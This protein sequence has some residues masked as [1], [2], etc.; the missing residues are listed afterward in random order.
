MDMHW[1]TALA[2]WSTAHP[3]LMGLSVLL[4]ACAES[5]AIVGLLV[6]GASLL[7]ACGALIGLG[8]LPLAPIWAWAVAGAVIGDWASFWLGRRMRSR[9]RGLWPLNRHPEWL[10]RGERFF[11]HHGGK[12][13]AIGRFVGPVRA[14]VPLIAGMLDMSPRRF[15][16]LNLL[17][18]L[19]WA[20]A[21]LL[22]GMALAAT[23]D[24]AG[25]V[26]TRLLAVALV[27]LVLLWLLWQV[28]TLLL[29]RRPRPLYLRIAAAAALLVFGI[30]LHPLAADLSTPSDTA[31]WVGSRQ[32]LASALQQE[33]WS[34]PRPSREAW[35]AALDP[36]APLAALP[37]TPNWQPPDAIWV[38]GDHHGE[39]QVLR[40]WFDTHSPAAQPQWHAALSHQYRRACGWL[41][42]WAENPATAPAPPQPAALT[43]D[44]NAPARITASG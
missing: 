1:F 19:L 35:L 20:P 44:G 3:Q 10:E 17:S 23:L 33:G 29:S 43:G 39:R 12:S 40:L 36:A 24:R 37:V 25:P 9:T 5:L 30:V 15:M 16:L 22:P 31:L 2:D 6:P 38:R 13:V 34:R 41:A 14:V 4:I 7:L 42:C 18:A 27:A 26:V 32:A 11:Q 21:Y 28:S 8:H